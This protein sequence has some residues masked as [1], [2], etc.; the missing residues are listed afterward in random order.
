M[1]PQ[2]WKLSHGPGYFTYEELLSQINSKVVYVHKD[3]KAKATSNVSQA[4]DFINA[5]IGDY[6]YLTHGNQGIYLLGQFV[7]PINLFSQKGNGWLERPYRHI[8][9]AVK[10]DSYTGPQKWW[11]P[12]DNSTFTRIPNS[13]VAVFEEHILKPFFGIMLSDYGVTV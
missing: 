7:G 3:T 5:A 13:E 12:N 6:F 4:E 10:K 2:F 1:K 11:S 9:S 8:K